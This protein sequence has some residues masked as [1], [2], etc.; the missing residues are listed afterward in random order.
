MKQSILVAA[1][2]AFLL[3]LT[4]TANAQIFYSC[5]SCQSYYQ[6]PRLFPRLFNCGACMTTGSRLSCGYQPM[7]TTSPCSS[8]HTNSS[9]STNSCSVEEEAPTYTAPNCADG[10]CEYVPTENGNVEIETY[11]TRRTLLD[12]LN[13]AR[14]RFGLPSL[15][16]DQSLESGASIQA[17]ICS[18]SGRLVHAYGVAEI[19]AQNSSDFDGA[20]NQWLN[21]PAHRSLLL[22]AGFRRCGIG[23]VRDGYGRSWYAVQ[24]R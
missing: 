14:E 7:T 17:S 12:R 13:A 9:R 3:S 20:V 4:T 23:L 11:K 2:S 22:S 21:S 19:L 10:S 5:G 24:F 18:R 15:V 8:C 1:L 6:R 16:L